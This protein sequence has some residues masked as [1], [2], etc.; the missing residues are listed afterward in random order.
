MH[1][2]RVVRRHSLKDMYSSHEYSRVMESIDEGSTSGSTY[3]SSISPRPVD[4]RRPRVGGGNSGV[5]TRLFQSFQS[6]GTNQ[7]FGPGLASLVNFPGVPIRGPNNQATNT[8]LVEINLTRQR[9]KRDLAQ[10]ND[11]F[12]QYVEKVRFL[13]AQNRK[14]LIELEALKSRAGQ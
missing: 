8:A 4:L 13:E 11:K 5:V 1:L 10:L 2:H 12:A 7:S 3:H 9:D 6:T 14:L